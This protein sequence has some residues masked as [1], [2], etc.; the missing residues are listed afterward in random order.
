MS[1]KS[2]VISKELLNT[3]I[4]ATLEDMLAEEGRVV[5]ERPDDDIKLF[6]PDGIFDSMGL[7][8]FLSE[9]EARLKASTGIQFVLAD[10]RAFSEQ[11]SPFRSLES[12]LASI[13]SLMAD[14]PGTVK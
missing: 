3:I 7:V 9:L 14:N 11:R 8:L 12:L 2:P 4:R 1:S 5:P 6:G 13:E 10:D